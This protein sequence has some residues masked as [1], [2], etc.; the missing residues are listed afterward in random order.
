MRLSRKVAGLVLAAVMSAG[1]TTAAVPASAAANYYT[2]MSG[3]NNDFMCLQGAI[4]GDGGTTVVQASC[5]PSN[6]AQLWTPIGIGFNLFK[7]Q[8]RAFGL[9]L[10][11]HGGAARGTLMI[12]WDC[13][14][15]ISNERWYWPLNIPGGFGPIGSRV[16]G[17]TG[18]CLDVPNAQTFPGLAMQLWTCNGTPAQQWDFPGP[19]A[20]G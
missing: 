14:A 2:I 20:T 18:Y 10:D 11:A 19:F 1:L 16:S 6:Q 8:N 12:L 15:D 5:D 13:G 9:C 7:F 3:N 4:A 17:S